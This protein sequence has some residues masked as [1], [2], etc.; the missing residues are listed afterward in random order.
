MMNLNNILKSD[1]I[2]PR[3]YLSNRLLVATPLLTA[4]EFSQT[5]ILMCAHDSEGAMGIIINHVIEKVDYHHLFEQLLKDNASFNESLPVHFGGPVEMNRGFIVYNYNEFPSSETFMVF[6]NIAVSSSVNVLKE[7]AQ[8]KGPKHKLLALGY[9]GWSA[10]QLELEMEANNWISVPAT[11]EL[12]FETDN[13]KKWK[14]A[15]ESHGIDI[16]RVTG[17][18]GH[19]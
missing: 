3:G 13:S 9:V 17:Y 8:G 2:P 4:P 6:N 15:A 1:V 11:A 18:T 14:M 5:V 12:I 16:S 10:S 7:I 19:A